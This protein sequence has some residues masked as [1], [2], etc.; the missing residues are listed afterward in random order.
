MELR[1]LRV[2]RAV[3]RRLSFTR[4]ADEIGYA[5][6]SVT[7]Q[8]KSLERE[9][10][11]A[12]FDRL[13]RG[14]SLT[15]A[16]RSLLGHAE[17]LLEMEE[18]ARVAVAGG[19]EPAGTLRVSAPETLTTYRLPPV[20][21]S[22]RERYPT[23]HLVFNP[24]P[25]GTL[26]ARLE[27][28]LREGLVDLAFVI[29]EPELV[30]GPEVV[31]ETLALERLA[32]IAPPDHALSRADVVRPE[33][34]SRETMLLTEKGCGY[35]NVFERRMKA[36]GVRL[37]QAVEFAS[38]EAIKRCVASGMGVAVLSEVSVE[39]EIERGELVKLSWP[40]EDFLVESRV[41][42]H[43]DKWLSPTISAF[44]HT[45]RRILRPEEDTTRSPG[46]TSAGAPM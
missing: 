12:L 2:F 43:R 22:F 37:D 18:R 7:A 6:S 38:G 28:E 1:Q 5:Q 19:D 21:A 42:Y 30:P 44:M 20:M 11:V 26:D 24:N 8:I 10:G 4:A 16:G 40:Q 25:T 45:A 32:L 14:V 33:D 27:R 36:S 29:E 46:T 13:G 39:R 35:R 3:A 9:L 31:A 41:V 23:V 15:D 17:R 34:V